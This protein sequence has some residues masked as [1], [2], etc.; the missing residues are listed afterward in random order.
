MADTEAVLAPPATSGSRLGTAASAWAILKKLVAE[1]E[2]RAPGRATLRGLVDGNRPYSDADLKRLGQAWRSNVNFKEA[3]GIIGARKANFTELSL[4]VPRLVDVDVIA[5]YNEDDPRAAAEARKMMRSGIV[6][7]EE[8]S[9]LLWGWD[10]FLF[11]TLKHQVEL[12]M[13]GVGPVIFPDSDSW[14]FKALA[15]AELLVPKNAD[16]NPDDMELFALRVEFRPHQ[17]YKRISDPAMVKVSSELGWNPAAVR[18]ALAG[19]WIDR[20]DV[21]DTTTSAW[22]RAQAELK[23]GDTLAVDGVT[24]SV[25]VNFIF[26][27]TSTDK[28]GMAILNDKADAPA[29]LF[30]KEDLFP[31]MSNVLVLF[32]TEIGSGKYHSV[33]G[34]AYD[35]YDHCDVSNRFLNTLI[36]GANLASTVVVTRQPGQQMDTVPKVVRIG[37]M[38]MLPDGFSP[39]QGGFSPNL[40]GASDVRGLLQQSLNMNVGLYRPGSDELKGADAASA[41]GAVIQATQEAR[42][43]KADVL[44]Y[45]TQW[46]RLYREVM[47]R[48]LTGDKD[49]AVS[50]FFKRCKQRGVPAKWLK[51][52]CIEVRASRAIGWGSTVMKDIVSKEV[53]SMSPYFPPEGRREAVRTRLLAL[54]G[55]TNARRFLPDDD[56]LNIP[57][58]DVSLAQLENDAMDNGSVATAGEDQIH[59]LHCAVHSQPLQSIVQGWNE[60]QRQGADMVKVASALNQ[61]IQHFGSH[62]DFMSGSPADIN[63]FGN[64]LSLFKSARKVQPFVERAARQQMEAQAQQQQAAM[65][66][67]AQAD[68]DTQKVQGELQLKAAKMLGELGI[69]AEKM[70]GELALQQ[71]RQA[72]QA[73]L[74]QLEANLDAALKRQRS[75]PMNISGAG[76]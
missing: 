51:A 72:S 38:T 13:Y 30:L 40:R 31:S 10:G 57:T 23:Q 22:E 36:D 54:V 27:K 68:A 41:R 47:R 34:L 59:V 17:L 20:S 21:N 5:T 15:H 71:Q 16:A 8:F 44:L 24:R 4:E 49:E 55:P 63:D 1:D 52:D 56:R 67:A 75:V 50:T 29:Y 61:Y 43:E 9:R 14:K 45:Y 7:A 28:V 76:R 60:A 25:R 46:D 39:V 48:V 19:A 37:P 69:K 33:R 74:D 73:Y 6:I 42:L 64:F 65:E 62:L 12:L 70:R 66:Q 11:H 26:W 3:R 18:D 35:I 58:N 53:L 32:M 2:A